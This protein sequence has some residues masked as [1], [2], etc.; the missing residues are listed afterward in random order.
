M[1]SQIPFDYMDLYLFYETSLVHIRIVINK[2]MEQNSVKEDHTI[3]KFLDGETV[4][5]SEKTPFCLVSETT[6]FNLETMDVRYS[7]IT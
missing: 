1:P 2:I 6:V 5:Y 3:K 4:C 7:L